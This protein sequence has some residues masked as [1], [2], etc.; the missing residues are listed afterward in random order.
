[1]KNR[2]D[3]LIVV[4]CL[5]VFAYNTPAY[6]KERSGEKSNSL[7]NEAKSIILGDIST[8]SRTENKNLFYVLKGV[9]DGNI[10]TVFRS[11]YLL[12]ELN[13]PSFVFKSTPLSDADKLNGF[14]FKGVLLLHTS[15][16]RTC[17]LNNKVRG[18]WLTPSAALNV[19]FYDMSFTIEKQ[20]N[21]W[22]KSVNHFIKPSTKELNSCG[23]NF[24][25]S[26]EDKIRIKRT[27]EKIAKRATEANISG[28][29]EQEK[30]CRE[31]LDKDDRESTDAENN[32][33]V[34]I[35]AMNKW[36]TLLFRNRAIGNDNP[37]SLEENDAYKI[38]S[39]VC[40]NPTQHNLCR[41]DRDNGRVY[42]GSYNDDL[43]FKAKCYNIKK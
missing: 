8:K 13:D 15:A 38:A 9:D 5:I 39:K 27:E 19:L 29:T 6:S 22:S 26:A 21:E 18:Q 12:I 2:I 14:E 11:D 10:F 24:G 1:M 43:W 35:A 23:N 7:S 34:C 25:P 41:N 37:I 17:D 4:F 32:D 3:S 36:C 28:E 42:F 20:N 40:K 16:M 33:S 30:Q 31:I